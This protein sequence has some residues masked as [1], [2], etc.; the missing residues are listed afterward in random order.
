MALLPATG[1]A[2]RPRNSLSDTA[3]SF[4]VVAL[5]IF[6]AALAGSLSRPMG[7]LAVF[8]PAN[9]LLAGL[10]IRGARLR[11]LT[12]VAAAGVGYLASGALVGD[13]P[14]LGLLMTTANLTGALVLTL[15]FV[16]L[17]EVDRRLERP[18]SVALLLLIVAAASASAAIIGGVASAQMSGETY[19]HAWRGWLSA[20]M[21]NY[22]ALL[23]LVLTM[24]FPSEWAIRRPRAGD[25]RAWL[26]PAIL[27]VL[28]ISLSPLLP[29]PLAVIVP[30][31][32][33]AWCAL[34]LP[35]PGTALLVL[36]YSGLA[37]LGIKLGIFDF[38]FPMP[39]DDD[40]IT[41][42]HLGVALV[43]LG[44]ILVASAS[45]ERRRRYDQLERLT[46]LDSLTE[47]LTRRAF[48]EAGQQVID[49]LRRTG[50]PV[51]VLL[52]DADH[53]KAIND[54]H[55]HAGGDRALTALAAAMR[56]SIR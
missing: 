36:I 47:A 48:E 34:V 46:R 20:E 16:A 33:L 27:A 24:P 3:R 43:A 28:A 29:N 25:L 17:P 52:C 23:P 18:R 5:L 44:P 40:E 32:A 15:F 21:V 30:I 50:A 41:F 53:F 35:L 7:F 54:L 49:R 56:L 51:A 39:L 10:L 8:W 42:A 55:G 4:I 26:P 37:M 45:A 1:D 2:D 38:G 22:L 11:S 13:V 31:P 14:H 12:V 19:L 6:A 9:A